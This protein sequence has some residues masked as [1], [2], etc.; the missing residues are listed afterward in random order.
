[1]SINFILKVFCFLNI[2]HWVDII[3][4]RYGGGPGYTK[5]KNCGKIKK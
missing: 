3:P 5:C 1:M 2:H 4:Q